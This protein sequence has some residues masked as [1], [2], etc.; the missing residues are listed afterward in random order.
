MVEIISSNE[1]ATNLIFLPVKSKFLTVFDF[2][3]R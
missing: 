3:V 1:M 2:G